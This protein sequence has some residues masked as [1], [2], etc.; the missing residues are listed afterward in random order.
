MF[1]PLCVELR[2][3]ALTTLT[4][5]HTFGA[6]GVASRC[7]ESL[8]P[9]SRVKPAHPM[10]KAASVDHRRRDFVFGTL[11]TSNFD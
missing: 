9:R 10:L 3:E 2:I 1:D 8:Q 11:V 4:P 5:A 6:L 7:H